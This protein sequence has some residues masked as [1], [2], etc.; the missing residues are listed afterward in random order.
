MT[1]R[2]SFLAGLSLAASAL[3]LPGCI[4][5]A[6]NGDYDRRDRTKVS[7]DEANKV[8]EVSSASNLPTVRDRYADQFAKLAPGMSTDAFKAL[9]PAATFVEQ[10]KG[11]SGTHE[12]YSLVAKDRYRYRGE[13]Y[14]YDYT[15]EVWFYF[16]NGAFVK[17]G[18]PGQWPEG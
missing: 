8:Q 3:I 6:D 18:K 11:A 10:R 14:V 17:W 16:T 2:V 12:A 13:R 7:W 5:V 9:L 4:I 1:R 15:D